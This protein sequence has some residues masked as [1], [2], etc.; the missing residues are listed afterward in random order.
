MSINTKR[1]SMIMNVHKDKDVAIASQS[2]ERFC[3]TTPGKPA[4]VSTRI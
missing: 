2:G 4:V 3:M 1:A